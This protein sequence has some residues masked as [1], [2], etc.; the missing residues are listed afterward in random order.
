MTSTCGSIWRT[1]RQDSERGRE[2]GETAGGIVARTT[3][4]LPGAKAGETFY[5]SY[6]LS[7]ARQWATS[8]GGRTVRP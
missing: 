6:Y 2:P 1:P 3:T 5:A 7:L 8:L 4:W